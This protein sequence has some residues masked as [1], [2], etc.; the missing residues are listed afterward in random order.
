MGDVNGSGA[1]ANGSSVTI[2]SAAHLY[3]ISGTLNNGQIIVDTADEEKVEIT[4]NAVS[5]TCLNSAPINI[6]NGE[7]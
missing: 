4:L 5:I 2:T 3:S 6:R 1:T 7:V